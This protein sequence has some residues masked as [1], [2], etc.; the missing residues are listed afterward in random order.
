ML[1][2]AYGLN[3]AGGN[4]AATGAFQASPG[5]QYSVDQAVDK[6]MRSQSAAGQLGSG[7]TTQAVTTLAQ[8]LANQDYSQWLS[9]LTGL[10]NSGQSAANSTLAGNEALAGLDTG[11]GHDLVS[12]MQ[13][14]TNGI[15]G[16]ATQAGQATDAAKMANQNLLL[17]LLGSAAQLGALQAPGS[18]SSTGQ[19]VSGGSI[20]GN[21]LASLGKGLGSAGSA[22]MAAL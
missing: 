21:L 12:N 18:V 2:N 10:S 1:G 6:A 17:G 8:N 22:I 15:A 5:Y 16:Q 7:N 13:W 4:A 19:A 20:G 14:G 3:G 9:G 11:Y